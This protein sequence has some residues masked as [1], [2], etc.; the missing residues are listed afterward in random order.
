[1]KLIIVR[2]GYTDDLR[3]GIVQ[4]HRPIPLNRRGQRQAK[5][6]AQ[7]L[8]KLKVNH[9]YSSDIVRAKQTAEAIA[10][11]HEHLTVTYLPVLREKDAGI[12]AG[13][14]HRYTKRVLKKKYYSYS[15]RPRGGESW[16]DV[17]E[18]AVR[19]L[20]LFRRRHPR[21][22][23]LVVSHGGWIS[24]LLT[25]I[26]HGQKNKFHPEYHHHNTGVSIVRWVKQ[27]PVLVQLNDTGHLGRL[28]RSH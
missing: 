14:S 2:H 25:Y 28:R 6:L 27:K 11:Y 16:S 8:K 12:F 20:R 10:V 5:L 15:H 22:T 19:S 3:Q 21:G 1:M 13:Q 24:A 4:G 17:S 23:V 9:I 18:R 7:A 26:F